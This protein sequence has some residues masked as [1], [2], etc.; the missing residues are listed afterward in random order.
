MPDQII[1]K[2]TDTCRLESVTD[3]TVVLSW[4][5]SY[6]KTWEPWLEVEDF[7]DIEVDSQ[8]RVYIAGPDDA[9]PENDF[10][11]WKVMFLEAAMQGEGTVE[12]YA[13]G[14]TAKRAGRVTLE[15]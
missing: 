1:S 14:S 13:R 4:K 7:L 5:S 3:I 8:R 15:A 10:S 11:A 6:V 9:L 2:P 12:V